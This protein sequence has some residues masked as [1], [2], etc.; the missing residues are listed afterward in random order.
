MRGEER[1]RTAAAVVVDVF[2]YG[3]GYR[4]A[5]VGGGAAPQLVEEYQRAPAHVVED[6]GGLV[7]LHHEGGFARRY[8]VAGAHAGENLVYQTD[9]GFL[10]GDIAAGLRHEGDEGR[11]AQE[12]RFTRHVGARNHHHLRLVAVESQR[13]GYVRFA[14]R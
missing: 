9:A 1:A 13:V 3:P 2:H 11:L 14:G 6:G 12:R 8:V 5:V 4:D 10:R 7:H